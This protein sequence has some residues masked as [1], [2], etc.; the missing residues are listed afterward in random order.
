MSF[1]EDI[2]SMRE[3]YYELERRFIE[4]SRIIPM[5][6]SGDTYSPR[7]YDIL[8]T[9]CGQVENLLRLIC[10]QLQLDYGDNPDFPKYYD[11]LNNSGILERQIVDY[12]VGKLVCKPFHVES[13]QRSPFWWRAYNQTKHKLP[14][15][16][17]EGNLKN[18]IHA[19]TGVYALQC[20]AVY[21]IHAGTKILDNG[22]WME[23][24]AL[25]LK[26]LLP[27]IVPS[28]I[29]EDVRPHSKIFYPVSYYRPMG[30][31]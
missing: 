4:I 23:Q 22:E 16:Y 18:T 9:A 8:Q 5:D 24:E 12:F 17:K 13:D 7:L 28:W 15:G 1:Q 29:N 20:I 3:S 25:S 21:S 2:S 26:T 30:G 27:T 6:N 14:Q 31:L 19:L 11:T 10:D